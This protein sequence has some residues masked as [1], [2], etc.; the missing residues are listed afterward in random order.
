M[1]TKGLE[2]HKVPSHHKGRGNRVE[3]TAARASPGPNTLQ[4]AEPGP[5]H[6][7]GM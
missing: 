6:L 7:L 3:V 4:K 1:S 5:K 2:A